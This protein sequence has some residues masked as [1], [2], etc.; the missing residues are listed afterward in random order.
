[1]RQRMNAQHE[2]S[3]NVLMEKLLD[4]QFG[5]AKAKKTERNFVNGKWDRSCKNDENNY[6]NSFKLSFPCQV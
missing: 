4:K 5:E 6:I 1:M 3:A 2:A